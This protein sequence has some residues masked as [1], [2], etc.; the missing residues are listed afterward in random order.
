MRGVSKMKIEKF[1]E[2]LR[3]M[4]D[5]PIWVSSEY[6]CPRCGE[7]IFNTWEW[8]DESIFYSPFPWSE[9]H[10]EV[11]LEVHEIDEW[12]PEEWYSWDIT[13]PFEGD[14]DGCEYCMD[15]VPCEDYADIYDDDEKWQDSVF[16]HGVA[17]FDR[18]ED[19][20]QR[21]IDLNTCTDLQ[22]CTS[23]EMIGG[24]GISLS[25]D[26]LVAS[27]E[28]LYSTINRN[29]G[30]RFFDRS[31]HDVVENVKELYKIFGDHNEIVLTNYSIEAIW[32]KNY[33]EEYIKDTLKELAKS[34]GVFFMEVS[35]RH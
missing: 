11:S 14:E 29:T 6:I 25:G 9:E 26:I 33:M 19:G 5:Y 7:H 15:L 4:S 34:L 13:V 28:D 32:C 30:K 27:N 17:A 23:T 2:E 35:P 31:R 12:T 21:I 20:I 10:F 3:T 24:Y 16:H 18:S 22:I 8:G 1:I